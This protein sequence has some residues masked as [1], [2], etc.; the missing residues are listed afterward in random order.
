M[1][2]DANDAAPQKISPPSGPVEVARR[3]FLMGGLL[4]A[5]WTGLNYAPQ[6]LS[7]RPMDFEQYKARK[8]KEV[9]GAE[10]AA[11]SLE[12]FIADRTK[13]RLVRVG[14]SAR[15]IGEAAEWKAFFDGVEAACAGRGGQEWDRRFGSGHAEN[16]LFF[17]PQ[18]KALPHAARLSSDAAAELT[19]ERDFAYV[20]LEA[21]GK[22][23]YLAVSRVRGADI[24]VA[25]WAV[26]RPHRAWAPWILA[27]G[28]LGYVLLP[29]PRHP[30]NAVR[31]SLIRGAIL[32]DAAGGMLAS[33]FFALPILALSGGGGPDLGGGPLD[34]HTG[35]AYFTLVLWTLGLFGLA[36]SAVAAWYASFQLLILPDSLRRNTLLGSREIAYADVAEAR[37]VEH[38]LPWWLRIPMLLSGKP[39]MMGLAMDVQSGIGMSLKDGTTWRLWLRGLTGEEWLVPRLRDAGVKLAPELDAFAPK[40]KAPKTPPSAV[41]SRRMVAQGVYAGLALVLCA[42]LGA[43]VNAP[44][45]PHAPPQPAGPR[46][47]PAVVLERG[48]IL[49]EMERVNKAL[50]LAIERTKKGTPEEKKGALEEAQG[51]M[52]EFEDLKVREEKLPNPKDPPK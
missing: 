19:G 38:R 30:A 13:D 18:E 20:L 29:W 8:S 36:L 33:C 31:Y 2:N 49:R 22:A 51:L 37:L 50:A 17:R 52:K 4:G 48:R 10:Y 27:I 1:R 21:E 24:H 25:P 46:P 44:P 15:G 14:D 32:P 43:W 7:I 5:L 41:G 16:N 26:S 3:L 11:M 45:A 39:H 35:A 6:L 42:A 23:R 28:L 9:F 40:R 12:A 34:F 47:D